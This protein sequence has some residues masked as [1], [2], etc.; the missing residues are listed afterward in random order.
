MNAPPPLPAST[1]RPVPP[2]DAAQGFVTV[3]AWLT[4]A[5]GA[6]G[7]GTGLLQLLPAP[8]GRDP[9]IQLLLEAL[10][11]GGLP[12]PPMLRWTLA[13]TLEISLVS[14]VLSAL[15]LWLG[16]GLLRRLE[17]ARLGFIV[18]LVVGTVLTFGLV[19]LLPAMIEQTLSM[20]FA[21][22]SPG[23]PL[24]PELAGMTTVAAVFSGCVAVVF[25]VLHGGI[26]WKLCTAAVRA[27]FNADA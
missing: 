25:A 17:W 5:L 1:A 20:Q 13:H 10:R 24:P 16:W 22:Q 18:Y 14:L 3:L 23:Q 19:W 4:I 2:R 15:T 8:G 7:V 26:I 6:L 9:N 11:G 21:L 27:Q 12:L